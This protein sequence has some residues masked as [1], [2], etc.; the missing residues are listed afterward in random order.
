MNSIFI[1]LI[2]KYSILLIILLIIETLGYMA[3]PFLLSYVTLQTEIE[4]SAW[5]RTALSLSTFLI[6]IVFAILIYN[7]FRKLNIAMMPIVVLTVFSREI[8]IAMCLI[9]LL[10]VM[11]RGE[12]HEEVEG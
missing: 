9:F 7:D 12:S 11:F 8:G 4:F 5:L 1:G 10:Y 2:R 6:N 3:G